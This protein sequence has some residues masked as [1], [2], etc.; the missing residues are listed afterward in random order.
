[1]NRFFAWAVPVAL[2]VGG[3]LL[4]P[5]LWARV[6]DVEDGTNGFL[7]T[8]LVL[9]VTVGFAYLWFLR[10]R[11]HLPT[12]KF[13][14]PIVIAI[15]IGLRLALIPWGPP[16]ESGDLYRFLWD[17]GVAANG[18][19]PFAHSPEEIVAGEGV[20]ARLR[21]L[22]AEAGP[23]FD[24]VLHP[25]I[26]T[27]YPPV[28]QGAFVLAHW[29]DPWGLPGWL[30]VLFAFDVLTLI[31]LLRLLRALNLPPV[32]V[33]I[34]WWNPRI[35]IDVYNSAHMDLVVLPFVL[36]ALLLAIRN[37]P[38]RAG[39]LLALAVGAKLWPVVLLPILFRPLLAHPR[40]LVLPLLVFGLL[41]LLLAWP[42]L[43]GKLDQ[44]AGFA[45]YGH[46]WE[47]NASLFK[48]VKKA[49]YGT[50]ELMDKLPPFGATSPEAE[51][52]ARGLIATVLGVAIVLITRRD[53]TDGLDMSRRC[54]L[55]VAA[56][57]LLSPTQF[58][59]YYS[60]LIPFLA[61]QP[62]R[63]LLWLTPLLGLFYLKDPLYLWGHV[64]WFEN[65]IVWLEFVPVWTLL[66]LEW[67]ARRRIIHV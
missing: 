29:I 24:R 36:A 27:I 1:M 47:N 41:S 22:P 13:L 5:Y 64:D 52:V 19:N 56:V 66:I 8:A 37:K 33:L 42:I 67:R 31:V 61:L 38:I 7:I 32:A 12:G 17:G 58:P 16:P 51:W 21:A 43:A 25:H 59:W 39:A 48:L 26:R 45:A 4:L 57:F 63:S 30:A 44:N 55:V 6:G 54:G 49:V 62:R 2:L 35:P 65:W 9:H 53:I 46:F 23:V 18:F 3:M 15:G 14:L 11:A 50:F 40:R 60:W 34:Y 28:A 20:P 10:N